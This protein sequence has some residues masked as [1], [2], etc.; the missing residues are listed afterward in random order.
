M[1]FKESCNLHILSLSFVWYS[2]SFY[3]IML[4]VGGVWKSINKCSNYSLTCLRSRPFHRVTFLSEFIFWS[5]YHICHTEPGPSGT[6]LRVFLQTCWESFPQETF[7]YVSKVFVCFENKPVVILLLLL[8]FVILIALFST[9]E[10]G[11]Q[12]F[13][14]NQVGW[15]WGEI[16]AVQSFLS[17]GR[18][19][20][21]EVLCT[22][23]PARGSGR[24]EYE[25]LRGWAFT[26]VASARQEVSLLSVGSRSG[27]AWAS[28]PVVVFGW[29]V[30]IL[31]VVLETLYW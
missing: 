25:V 17:P 29:R 2:C 19:G 31:Q 26:P 8:L 1:D 24:G 11:F 12:E 7:L 14:T 4:W 15:G 23:P 21:F 5:F 10:A 18:A 9:G 6:A 27:P 3:L 16:H 30:R 20:S 13:G 28:V 22:Q